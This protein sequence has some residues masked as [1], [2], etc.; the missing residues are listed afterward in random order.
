MRTLSEWYE[1]LWSKDRTMQDVTLSEAKQI[2]DLIA[3]DLIGGKV[4]LAH[5]HALLSMSFALKNTDE[6]S[7]DYKEVA[8]T[9]GKIG[10]S[11]RSVAKARSSAINGKKGG[12]P[13]I[14]SLCG[15]L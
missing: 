3:N 9:L 14:N 5:A 10:G 7:A 1:Y 12:R 8:K 4:T 15:N 6:K 13:P 2:I 11:K